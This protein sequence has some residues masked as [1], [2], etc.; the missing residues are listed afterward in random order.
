[1]PPIHNNH[2][3]TKVLILR[4]L[5]NTEKAL[6]FIY[7][8]GSYCVVKLATQFVKNISSPKALEKGFFL[9]W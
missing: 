9:F 8:G 3:I 7:I 1:M 2:C 5:H 4:H 6:F